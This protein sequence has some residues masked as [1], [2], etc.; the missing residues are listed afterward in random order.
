MCVH[1][2]CA[3]VFTYSN[4]KNNNNK[5]GRTNGNVHGVF[6]TCFSPSHMFIFDGLVDSSIAPLL[7]ITKLDLQGFSI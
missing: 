4:N 7:K 1:G 6:V 3:K 5:Q 2:T